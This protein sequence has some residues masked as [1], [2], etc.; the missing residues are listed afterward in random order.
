M[1]AVYNICHVVDLCLPQSQ[2]NLNF[3]S[4]VSVIPLRMV[5]SCVTGIM[6]VPEKY[7]SQRKC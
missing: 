4:H 6:L 5:V 2:G 1:T 7:F 3:A